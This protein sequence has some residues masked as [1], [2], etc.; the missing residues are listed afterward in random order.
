MR[1]R[2]GFLAAAMLTLVL[3]GCGGR[4]RVALAPTPPKSVS[5]DIVTRPQPP[6]GAAPGLVIPA[7]GPDGKRITP[8]RDLGPR[9]AL[10]HVRMALNVAALSCR[11][12]DTQAALQNYNRMLATH[13]ALLSATNAAIDADYRRRFGAQAVPVRDAHNTRTYNFFA[14]PPVQPAFCRAAMGVGAEAVAMDATQLVAFAP[15]ALARLERP[16]FAFFDAYADYQA[17]AARW[18]DGQGQKAPAAQR[19]A[20]ETPRKAVAEPR[21][22]AAAA[23]PKALPKAAVAVDSASRPNPKPVQTA[24][25][26]A[27]V[28]QLGAVASGDAA[29]SA[30]QQIVARNDELE[31]RPLVQTR[32]EANG[33]TLHR[34]AAG[35][36][37]TSGEAARVCER[38][39]ARGTAC[40]VRAR[41]SA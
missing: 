41:D 21:R 29:R 28:V 31:G 24:D 9:E 19:V 11:N 20:A 22:V 30:W 38:L 17:D 15:T 36:F 40:F 18:R 6:M 1:K 3:A 14:L 8:N 4:S 34:I 5:V 2:D 26:G 10:W 37:D 32:A 12:A 16:F 27:F 25:A 7:V 39:K 13:N 33:R 35:G 23:V